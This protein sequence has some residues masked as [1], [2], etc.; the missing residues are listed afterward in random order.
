MAFQFSLENVRTKDKS[1][2]EVD[3]DTPTVTVQLRKKN[4]EEKPGMSSIYNHV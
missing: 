2:G 1:E 3:P 4:T